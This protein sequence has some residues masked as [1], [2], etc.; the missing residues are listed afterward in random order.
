MRNFGRI[1]CILPPEHALDSAFYRKNLTLHGILLTRE[2]HRLLEMTPLLERRLVK[3]LVDEVLPL[4]EVREAHRRL[5]S[6]HGRGKV[7]LEVSKD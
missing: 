6:G 7:V 3:P 5:D 4:A 2:R 1:A